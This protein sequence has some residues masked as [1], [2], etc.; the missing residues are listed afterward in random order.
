LS[1]KIVALMR[2]PEKK[3]P[4]V[5]EDK[6]TLKQD[7]GIEGDH[8]ADGGERQISLL[9]VAEKEWMQAQEVKGFC[10]KKYK[11][12]ILLDGISL[13]D[14]KQGDLLKCEE[15]VLELTSSIKSCH[16]ELCSLVNE[17]KC[18]LAGSSRFAKVK[19][20]GTIHVGM[21]AVTEK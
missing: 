1:G 21:S 18:I 17:G 3:A 9:T 14:C 4:A 20:G 16:P 10:F 5:M 19:Y 2:Y 11:E 12:N 6:L 13:S 8:H 7:F 15:V